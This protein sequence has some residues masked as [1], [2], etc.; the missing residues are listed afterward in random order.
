MF[1]FFKYIENRD[2]AKHLYRA[3]GWIGYQRHAAPPPGVRRRPLGQRYIWTL[4]VLAPTQRQRRPEHWL[5][6]VR[7]LR[8]LWAVPS[9]ASRRA[10]QSRHSS[11][12]D[13]GGRGCSERIGGQTRCWGSC[14]K[15]GP[16]GGWLTPAWIRTGSFPDRITTADG[17][18]STPVMQSSINGLF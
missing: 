2:E 3:F 9:S 13:P 16:G 14:C 7:W 12:P 8:R 4:C 15:G 10:R 17:Q 5:G 6:S 11:V 1:R 18:E